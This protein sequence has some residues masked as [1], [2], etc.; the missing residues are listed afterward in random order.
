[1][2]FGIG[3]GAEDFPQHGADTNQTCYD[4]WHAHGFTAEQWA[5]FSG[6]LTQYIAQTSK[7]AD[8]TVQQ[9]VALNSIGSK[10]SPPYDVAS[11]VSS[12]ALANGVGFGTENLGAGGYGSTVAQCTAKQYWCD[13]F[14]NGAGKVPLEFQP[15]DFTLQPGVNIVPLPKLL[16]YAMYNHAQIFELYAQEWLTADDP[17]FTPYAQHAAQ[18]N[19]ALD[20]AAKVLGKVVDPILVDVDDAHRIVREVAGD[21][22]DAQR[23][24]LAVIAQRA[25]VHGRGRER[26]PIISGIRKY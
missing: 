23:H 1:M 15:I 25:I 14:Q 13:A 21:R 2:R 18:W 12:V 8:A 5:K 10:Y 17:S 20:S 4:A 9:M 3:A 26:I 6:G 11:Y 24:L 19:A 22:P 7:R 16:P